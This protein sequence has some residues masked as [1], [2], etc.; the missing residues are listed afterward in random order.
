VDIIV[1]ASICLSKAAL[2]IFY[3]SL[4]YPYLQYMREFEIILL[5]TQSLLINTFK[6]LKAV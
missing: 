3:F 4:V 1:K 2:R 6:E 5:Q